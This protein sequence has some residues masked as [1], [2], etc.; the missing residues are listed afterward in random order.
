MAGAALGAGDEVVDLVDEGTQEWLVLGLEVVS[1]RGEGDISR[2]TDSNCSLANQLL[3]LLA[4]VREFRNLL[5]HIDIDIQKSRGIL[6][7]NALL[8]AIEEVEEPSI[9]LEFVLQGGDDL[10]EFLLDVHNF[11]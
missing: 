3:S 4:D 9:L 8:L 7:N 11:K 5:I 6:V 10:F 2:L 1:Q